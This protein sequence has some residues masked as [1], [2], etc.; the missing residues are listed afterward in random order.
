MYTIEDKC[1]CSGWLAW[2]AAV[3]LLIGSWMCSDPV[4]SALAAT[5]ASTSVYYHNVGEH[6]TRA[7]IADVGV[8]LALYARCVWWSV[9]HG[10]VARCIVCAS[11]VWLQCH[12]RHRICAGGAIHPRYQLAT[13]IVTATSLALT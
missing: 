1:Q 11:L 6:C 2:T 4:A 12:P 8:C 5:L 7:R 9:Y 3:P 10:D 13:Q